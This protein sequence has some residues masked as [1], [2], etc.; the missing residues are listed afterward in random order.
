MAKAVVKEDIAKIEKLISDVTGYTGNINIQRMGGLTNHS[1]RAELEDGSLYAVRIPGDG[2]EDMIDRS[3]EK[4]ST[5]LACDLEIDSPM[6]FF[7]DDGSKVT[8]YI[9]DAQT[10]SKVT[11]QEPE[12]IH[13]AARIFKA[14]HNCGKD[15]GVPFEVFDMAAEYEKILVDNNVYTFDDYD[16][17]KKE[18]MRVKEEIDSACHPEKV[19]CHNDPLCE[20]WVLGS[21]RMYLIDWEY[22]GMNDGMWDVADLSIE[23]EYNEAQDE[24]F[25]KAYLDTDEIDGTVWKHFLANKIYVDFLWTLWAKTRVPFDGQ[26]MED[27]AAERYQRLKDNLSAYSRY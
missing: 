13:E 11:M 23:A 22:S 9:P 12:K 2:T 18:V 17:V 26:S 24:E 16:M 19:P 25:L 5:Q 21:D 10:M 7:G 27:W 6:L 20:N 1:Y 4:I 3:N 14:L 8:A 15:T